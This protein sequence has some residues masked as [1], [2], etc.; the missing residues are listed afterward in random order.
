MMVHIASPFFAT[1][2]LHC[3]HVVIPKKSHIKKA[4]A[5]SAPRYQQAPHSLQDM[6]P[7]SAAGAGAPFPC[8][9][10]NGSIWVLTAHRPTERSSLETLRAVRL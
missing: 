9:L 7:R 10:G 1:E 6:T 5:P 3:A 2:P 8:E 4:A